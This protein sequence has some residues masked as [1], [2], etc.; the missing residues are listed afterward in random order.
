MHRRIRCW[1]RIFGIDGCRDAPSRQGVVRGTELLSFQSG[2]GASTDSFAGMQAC[3]GGHRGF[4]SLQPR[5]VYSRRREAPRDRFSKALVR[6]GHGSGHPLLFGNQQDMGSEQH[7][8]VARICMCHMLPPFDELGKLRKQAVLDRPRALFDGIR[9]RLLDDFLGH[10][11]FGSRLQRCCRWAWP[12]PWRRRSGAI[13]VWWFFESVRSVGFRPQ[14]QAAD[15]RRP[16]TSVAGCRLRGGPP[17]IRPSFRHGGEPLD[18][19]SPSRVTSFHPHLTAQPRHA[20]RIHLAR[21]DA[22]PANRRTSRRRSVPMFTSELIT[23]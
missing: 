2:E 9:D 5:M 8:R 13:Y 17:G 23:C 7:A 4:R 15:R 18:Q 20:L 22:P 6:Q 11:W 21:V 14:V 10:L 16:D 3:Q 12:R 19:R 1:E